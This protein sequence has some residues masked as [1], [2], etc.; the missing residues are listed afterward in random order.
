MNS[1]SLIFAKVEGPANPYLANQFQVQSY[2][3]LILVDINKSAYHAFKGERT[4][5]K[6]KQWITS[7]TREAHVSHDD[8]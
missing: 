2:P 6:V 7:L 4:L 5:T 8:N 3:T 1:D